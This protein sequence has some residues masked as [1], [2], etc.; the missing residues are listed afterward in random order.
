M[1]N[2]LSKWQP[3]YDYIIPVKVPLIAISCVSQITTVDWEIFTLKIIHVKNF[4]IVKFSRFRSVDD[5][6][7]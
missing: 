4:R 5:F 6:N 3:V 7:M 2:L 1:Q